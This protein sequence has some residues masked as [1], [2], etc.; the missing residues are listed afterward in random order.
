[1]EGIAIIGLAGRFPGAGNV[2]VFWENLRHGVESISRFADAELDLPPLAAANAAAQALVNARGVVAD[3]ASFD[4]AFFGVHAREAELMDPQQRVFLECAWEAMEHAGYDPGRCP[5]PVG[6][7]AG[8][9]LNSYLLYN[10]C[11]DRDYIA[12]LVC[13]YQQTGPADFLGNEK[14]FLATRVSYKLNL[15]GPSLTVQTACSTSL[16]A[17]AQACQALLSYQCDLALAGGVSISFPQRRAYP[18][19]EGGMASVDG[20][21]RTFDAD[22]A[23]VVFSDGAGCVVLKRLSEAQA[24]G[25][26]IFAVIKGTAVNNDGAGKV[27]YSAP[28]ADGQAEVIQLA[29]ALAEVEPGSVSYVEAHGTATPL[30]DPIELAGLTQAFRAGGAQGNGFCAIGSL[31]TNVGHLETAS[32]V[33][34][35]IKTALALKHRAI[36]PSLHFQAANPK[37]DLA[38]S[39]FYVNT[40]L[41][42]WPESKDGLPRRAGVSSFGVGGTNAHAVLEEAPAE[43]PPE[44][45]ARGGQLF[46]LSAKTE[47]ALDTATAN[48]ARWFR[49]NPALDPDDAAFTL[50]V[51]R[52]PFACRRTVVARGLVDAVGA[53]EPLETRRVFTQKNA[54][55]QP[56]VAFLFPGQGAQAVNMGAGLYRAETVFREEIDRCAEGL[57]PWLDGI[58]LRTVIYPSVGGEAEAAARLAQ[59]RFTQPALFAFGYALAR[60]WMSWGVRPA[61]MLGHSVGEYVAACLAGVFSL[62][63][64]LRLVAERARVVQEQPGGVMLAVRLPEAELLPLLA[65][66]ADLSLA[67]VNSPAL[68]VVAGPEPAV[69]AFEAVL[70]TRRVAARRLQTSHAFHSAMLDAV[71]E[72]FAALVR[73]VPLSA[74]QIPFVSNVTGRLITDAEATDTLY[75]AR[76]LRGTVRFADSVG[77]LLRIAPGSIFLEAGPG[78]TLAPLARQHPAARD[79]QTVVLSTLHENRDDVETALGGLGRLWAEGVEVDWT[80]FHAGSRR[81]RVTLPTYPFE[82]KRYWVE[83]VTPAAKATGA[84]IPVTPTAPQSM[85]TAELVSVPP[86]PIRKERIMEKIRAVLKNLSGQDQSGADP[87]VTFLELGFD[88]L[89]LTQVAGTFR[90]EFG[91]KVTFRQLLEDY[92][93]MEALSAHLDAILPPEVLPSPAVSVPA[94]AP[95]AAAPSQPESVLPA[96]TVP[97]TNSLPSGGNGVIERVIQEQLRVM[98]QQLETLRGGAPAPVAAPAADRPPA[99]G[100]TIS[101]DA[102]PAK[103]ESKAFGPYRPIEKSA[104]GGFTE[105]QQRHLDALIALYTARTPKSKRLTQENRAHFSDPRTVSGFRQYWKEMV[106]PIVTDRSAGSRLWDI[107]GHEYVDLTMGFGTNLLGHSPAFITAALE[108]QLKRGVEVGPQSPLAGK[109]A[110]LLCEMTG[111]ERAAFTNTGSEAVLAAVRLARTVTGR[112]RIATC[113]GF[114]GINDEV[115]VRAN[116]VDGQRRSVPVAPGIPEHIVRDVL[117]V[118]Y[119]TA[120]GLELLRA[121]AHEL[122]AILIEPVQSRRP[123]LQP[124]EFLHAAREIAT[125]GGCALVFDEVITGFR[126]HPG[127]AQAYFGVQA[128]LATW[129]KVMGG[130]MPVGALTGKAEYMDALDGGAWQY[131]DGSFPEVGVTFFAGTYIRHPLTLAASWAIL[132]YLQRD[133]GDLQRRLNERTGAMVGELNR[134]FK[135]SGVPLHLENFAS[136]FYPHFDDE[137]RFGSLMYFHLR[138]RGVH[139]WEGRPCFLST[140][141][142]EAD[143]AFI[144]RAFKETIREMQAGGFLPGDPLPDTKQGHNGSNGH[145]AGQNGTT[146]APVARPAA[147][148]VPE[149]VPVVTATAKP[150]Q[151]S[152]YYFGN[153]PAAYHEDKYRLILESARFADEHGFTAVWLPERHFHAVGGFSPNPSL[154]AAALARDTRRIALR[155]GSVVLPL[156]HPVRVAEEWS[157]V[158]NLSHGRVGIS[159]ASG[160]HPNDFIFAPERFERRREICLED[161]ETIQKLWRGE[162]LPMRAG[163]NADFNVKLFPLP[164]QDHLPVW[165]TCIHEESFVK[166]GELGL[167]V[168]GYLMNQTVEEVAAKIAKYREALAQHGHDPAK[169][170]VT[171]LVHTFLGDDEHA[172]RERAR[173]PLREYLRSFLDNSQKRLESQNGPVDVADE[174]LEYLL[175]K[176]FNDYVQGKALIGTP[177]S[178]AGVVERLRGIGADEIGC[179][180]DFGVDTEAVLASLPA[181]DRLRERYAA[182]PEPAAATARELPFTESQRGLWVLGQ[183]GADALRAYHES[184]TLALHG[185]LDE[186]RLRGAL[187]AVVNRHEA[188]RATVHRDGET[189]VVHATMSPEFSVVDLSG[190]DPGERGAAC[191]RCLRDI[192]GRTFDCEQGPLLRAAVIRL[193]PEEHLLVLTFHHLLGNGPSYWAFFEELAALY[194][195]GRATLDKPLQL[196]EWVRWRNE[197]SARTGAEDEAFWVAQSAD[198]VPTLE[199]PAD[200]PRPSLRTHRGSRQRLTLDRELAAALRKVAAARRGSL[201]MLLLAAFEVLLHRLSGQDDLVVGV[202]YEGEGRALP[203]GERLFANTTNVLPLR[204]RVDEATTFAGLFAATKDRV[205]TANDHQNYFFGRLIKTL[206]LPH[207]PSRPPVFSV[208]FNYE[209]GKFERAFGGGLHAELVTEDVPYRCPRDTAMFEL[210]LNVGEKDGELHCECDHSTDLFDGE[211]VQR[212]LGH[213]RTLLAAIVANPEAD[214]RTLPLLD[215]AERRLVV[216][217]FNQTRVD[218]PLDGATLHGLIAAQ[219]QRTPQATALLFEG[220]SLSYADLDRQANRLAHHLQ[221]QGVGPG[222]LVGVCMERSPEMVV[223]LLGILKAGGAYVPLDPDYPAERLAFMMADAAVPVLLTQERLLAQ[224]P[225]H[226]ARVWCLDRDRDIIAQA[227]DG[228]PAG[229]AGP[230]DLAY[231][232]YTSGSTGQPKGAMNTHRGICNRL[233]WMQDAYGLAADDRVLQKTPFSFDVSVWEFFWPLLTGAALVL[234]R[235]RSHGDSDYLASLIAAQ[236][237]T[238]CHFV[239][240]MLAAFLEEPNLR[241]RCRSLRRVICSGE[242]L[243]WEL[244]ERFFEVLAG[245]GT[246]LHN[247][248]GPTEA[249]V[250]VTF[251]PCRP[252]TAERAV[253]IGRP[254]ANTQIYLLDPRGQPVPIGVPGELH[255]GGTGVGRGYLNRPELTAERFVPDPFSTDPAARLYRTGDLARWRADGTLLYLGR[256]DHQ[257][258]LRGFRIELGEIETLLGR[259]PG[260]RE[261]LVLAREDRP[262]ERRLVAYVTGE[263]APGAAL[264]DA[265]RASLPE[266][267]VPA[268]VVPLS[269]L[270]LTPNGKVDRRALPAPDFSGRQAE[271]DGVELSPEPETALEQRLAEIWRAVL[272]IARIGVNDHFFEL[273]GD[274]LT[275]LRLVNR[276][277][278]A[279]GG[280]HLS[281]VVVFEAPTIRRMAKMLRE[282][283]RA[284]VNRWLGDEAGGEAASPAAPEPGRRVDEEDVSRLRAI[285]GQVAPPAVLTRQ[286]KNPPAVFILSPM[287]SGSTLL[288]IMLA[289]N[290]RLFS[291]PELQLLQF[292]T[293]AERHDAFIGYERYMQEGTLRALMQI[294]GYDLDVARAAMAEREAAGWTVPRFYRQLQDQVAPRMLVD[295]TPD[296]ALDLAVL[297]RAEASFDGALYVHLARHPL[298]MIRSYEKGHFLMESPYRGRHDFTS[299]QMAE[300]LW[301]ISHRNILEFLRGVPAERQRRVRFE[302]IVARPQE[303]MRALSGFL[304]VD[305]DPA[306]AR[307]YDD[308]DKAR[309]T[310]GVHAMSPQVGDHNFEKHGALRPEVADQW[311]SECREDAVSAATW[312]VA[313]GFGYANPFPPSEAAPPDGQPTGASPEAAPRSQP[314][315]VPVPREGRRMKRSVVTSD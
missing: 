14:D 171:L 87:G 70:E 68:C 203:G 172:A 242:A 274:S 283:Y 226:A 67:A 102:V 232:I 37:L 173:G 263:P 150:L 215:A 175:D 179:F 170:H 13:G 159:I 266:Y 227:G 130:G 256:L 131:E 269:A 120:E 72:P 307:P 273:G 96:A 146:L 217:G 151:F 84:A 75:W 8:A 231:V 292:D 126:C 128:D 224:L 296:Y 124:R 47:T 206:N 257:V 51:G 7:W 6:V 233:L 138:A 234:A 42:P 190:I 194:A 121:H 187:Q 286:E 315:L 268:A 89:F 279:L 116:L 100:P 16:V 3:A 228:T 147:A 23:G 195:D 4:A 41:L 5:G 222:T 253:P 25:D 31:K 22:A 18:Y 288:R 313:A 314:L 119:G 107:D 191:A 284:A 251:W 91:V 134:F 181:L 184:T 53:L 63:D 262:G 27:S 65:H 81:R 192:E 58:D 180:I 136:L 115:L 243:P 15:R 277:R 76:H 258:K 282:N 297:R 298:G 185:P 118:D 40:K 246:T 104:S 158:D 211:T 205:L 54:R 133:G 94:P 17:V 33:A 272:G 200:R 201:F 98:A 34:A 183:T 32:G 221:A 186:P 264:R 188:L 305:Y 144:V 260:V 20:H 95:P 155:G 162:S 219:A 135:D 103:V 261:C 109:V 71:I 38:N 252:G 21:T 189:Q 223:A 239:P 99:P 168:L 230:D 204:S 169:G 164:V 35:I 161:I 280:E 202:P 46:V 24:D 66:G 137:I 26:Q 123:D 97:I 69:R 199:L 141:H 290:P 208:F 255:I 304:G 293:L 92:A 110:A 56:P 295:K 197:E 281:L 55:H 1:M 303:E 248:Y 310:D 152:L 125:Q 43:E 216:E 306:M 127:G 235:P 229:S 247:L 302:D 275:G 149:S 241:P 62:E 83:P 39:P 153:Y 19:Q 80:A 176:S 36:P 250:D 59:T 142:T 64:G 85:Q 265:L 148:P 44:P 312:E 28:S 60:L 196:G 294:H 308:P 182:I 129:G 209:T 167:G 29:Q 276:V 198:G 249:A 45:S 61:A 113:G 309:M 254:I 10:L 86:M 300:L 105:R 210:Y 157:M 240:P 57:L 145:H 74:P 165:L 79:P 52:A 213:Y 178:C 2:A 163:A 101:A 50:A 220:R 225:P 236:G 289:G 48:L 82:R 73:T 193:A 237:V 218:Y 271:A 88:S 156:H 299:F 207:D 30:G 93:T 267:M 111:A 238:T 212:W 154:L 90:K 285:I 259:Q 12:R 245:A 139:A 112:T 166:A 140:A 177:E 278:D 9:S 78:Q 132:N 291:P 106:Y 270:P 244:Q 122:A 11:A 108:D 311:R 174:D 117:V 143:V 49:E 301:L 114:H 214:V 160:W 77:E 287:R